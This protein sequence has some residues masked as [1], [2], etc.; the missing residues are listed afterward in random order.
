[1]CLAVP[2][3]IVRIFDHQGLRM[4]DVDFGGVVRR[5]CLAYVPEAV[6]DDYA[7]VHAGF[8]ISVVNQQEASLTLELMRRIEQESKP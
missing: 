1:M 3:R 6:I 8:A 5:I 7:V 4:G 2:G